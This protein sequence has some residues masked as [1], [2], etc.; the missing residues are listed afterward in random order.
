MKERFSYDPFVLPYTIGLIF[1]L[2]YLLIAF[3]RTV[4]SLPLEDRKKLGKHIF[5]KNIFITAK[6]VFADCLLHV[7][8]WKRNPLLGYMHT[9]LAFGW[10]MLILLGHI[11]VN[12]FCPQRLNLP[13]FPIFFRYFMMET[14]T[15]LQGSVFFFLMDFFLL[16]V[17]SGVTLAIIKRFQKR[18]FGM[19]RTTK[20]KWNDQ[21][22]VLALWSIFP[23]RFLAESFTSQISG[24][25]FLTRGF[26]MIFEN[27]NLYLAN[28]A[29]IRPMWWAY[30]SALGIFFFALPGSRFTHILSEVML[31]FMRNAGIREGDKNSGYAKV[32][33]YACARCGLCLDPCQMISAAKLHDNAT[34]NFTRNIRWWNYAEA[35]RNAGYCLM[36]DRCVQACPVGVNSVKLK[37]NVKKHKTRLYQPNQYQYIPNN[38]EQSQ[39][40]V[41]YF[42]GCMSHLTPA[43]K[44]SMLQILEMSGDPYKCLDEENTICC[45][46]PIAQLGEEKSAHILM[47]KNTRLIENANAKMLVTSCPICYKVFKDT[48]QLNIPVLH[49]TE[50]I[51]RLLKD[52]KIKV[53]KGEGKVVFHDSCELGRHSGIYDAPREILE[54]T[55]SLL[56]TAYD[57]ENALC[58]GNSVASEAMPFK[59]RRL[60]AED[61]LLKMTQNQPDALVTSCPACK[62]AF[63]D[64]NIL[65]VKDIAEVVTAQM[66]MVK[67]E[68]L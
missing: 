30:S 41:L 61:A 27:F 40:G 21:I 35:R 9:S 51:S 66:V 47:E 59:K 39:T 49:H 67:G 43:I 28:D 54:Q 24:G 25:S 20:L 19:K 58:C 68:Q 31:I 60:I 64:L 48:Y 29:L 38:T 18:A 12:F 57:K 32:E 56:T 52:G 1:V 8:I 11:E 22:A 44:K 33:I 5:S 17:L 34:V 42:A 55:S 36:C 14:E 50:Y 16:M 62:K 13:Y 53:A 63:A 3:I 4:K 26:S 65:P 37:L 15:T 10:F 7:K 2:S 23:L 6:D 45:G 46:R